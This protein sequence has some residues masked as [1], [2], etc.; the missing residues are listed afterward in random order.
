MPRTTRQGLHVL[1][2]PGGTGLNG[3]R[4]HGGPVFQ[5]LNGTPFILLSKRTICQLAAAAMK[6]RRLSLTAKWLPLVLSRMPLI[7]RVG[8]RQGAAGLLR[9]CT[10]AKELV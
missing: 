10:P 3:T 9:H 2:T 5:G 7:R 4:G 6:S 8:K 1:Y